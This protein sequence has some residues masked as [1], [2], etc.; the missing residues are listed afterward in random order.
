M[1]LVRKKLKQAL[2]EKGL[3]M[4]RASLQVGMNKTYLQQFIKKGTPDKLPE[5][6][7]Y[8]L[9]EITGLTDED[10]GGSLRLPSRQPMSEGQLVVRGQVRAGAWLDIDIPMDDGAERY[11]NMGPDSR[12]RVPQF[13]L[14][15]VGTSMNRYV[16]EGGF[17]IVASWPELGRELR[18]N[19]VVV[20]RR[21][22]AKTYEVTLKRAK[23][24][25]KGWE[26]WPDS[27]D[28]RWQTPVRFDEKDIICTVIGLVIGR[29]MAD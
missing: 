13:A 8:Q 18:D 25:K 15:V 29:Y 12:Y 22:R 26:L 17:V 9:S 7:R 5:D 19:D 2:A 27:D 23:A 28:P 10:L 11:V 20:V 21:E 1:D 16:Q 24:T 6:I 4:T 14:E 3:S